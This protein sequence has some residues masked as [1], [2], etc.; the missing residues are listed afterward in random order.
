MSNVDQH[1]T[2]SQTVSGL[3]VYPLNLDPD[4]IDL[5][6]IAHHTARIC[7]FLGGVDV[8]L[9]SVAEH[10]V[11]VSW[12]AEE[13]TQK[14]WKGQGPFVDGAR[15]V[16]HINYN[17]R[18]GLLHDAAEYVLGDIARPIKVQPGFD[19][20]RLIYEPDV[21]KKIVERYGLEWQM[22]S[23]VHQADYELCS[24]EALELKAPV[25]RA[26]RERMVGVEKPLP[27]SSFIRQNMGWS[28]RV[29]ERRYLERFFQLWPK[30][31]YRSVRARKG[32]RR[33]SKCKIMK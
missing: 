25:L 32:S 21:L 12:R 33:R 11:R 2:W 3:A 6:D 8:D 31:T 7:R 14:R 5:H 4:L 20:Y 23:C 17:A 13:L 16:E 24:T 22:P 9:Y 10:C 1:K 15:I 18:W 27:K 26:W 19:P 28:A 29:A 30:E